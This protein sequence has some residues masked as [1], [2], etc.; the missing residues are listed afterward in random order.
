[1]SGLGRS[2]VL[3]RP[4][5]RHTWCVPVNWRVF[6]RILLQLSV[7]ISRLVISSGS[8]SLS[9]ELALGCFISSCVTLLRVGLEQR[10]FDNF[11]DRSKVCL[12]SLV[13]WTA[14]SRHLTKC[15]RQLDAFPRVR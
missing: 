9:C 5:F 13:V 10:H 12:A 8:R 2:K 6:L 15:R 7:S 1:M 11:W 3:G 4:P 14:H